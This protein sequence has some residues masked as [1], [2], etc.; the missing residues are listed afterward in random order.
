[1][2]LSGVRIVADDSVTLGS[3]FVAGANKEGFHLKNVNFRRDFS[4][5]I[6]ADV[7][8]A[9]AG[10][11]CQK[12]GA[13]LRVVRGME[14]GHVFKL[15]TSIA[16]KMGAFFTDQNGA[17][18]PVIMGS[19]GIGI[20]RLMSAVIEL[21]HDDKGIIWQKAIAPFQVYLGPL[22]RGDPQLGDLVEKLY[23]DLVQQGI[24]TLLDDRAE[25]SAGVKFNDA[26]LLGIPVR[27]TVSSRSLQKG[28]VELKREAQTY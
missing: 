7:A 21:N 16:E 8:K 17:S 6:L 27:L 20:G 19:Y 3:N 14:V 24:E 2:G 25:E 11:R 1:M 23:H 13:V 12:C 22:Y 5:D 26:D 9:R 15:G 28:G 10:D 4:A 18:R